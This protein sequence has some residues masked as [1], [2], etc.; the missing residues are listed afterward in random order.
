MA[1]DT[2]YASRASV[3]V[4]PLQIVKAKRSSSS[5]SRRA[6]TH[7][8]TPSLNTRPQSSQHHITPPPTPTLQ[9]P[10]AQ[11][12]VTQLQTQD[13]QGLLEQRPSDL[14]V[15]HFLRAFFPFHPTLNPSSNTVTLPLNIGDII[16]VHSV[17]TNGWADG[18]MLSSGSRGWLPTNY[19]EGYD[20][21]QIRPL[22]RA[23]LS[24]FDQCK[25]SGSH[26]GGNQG[27]VTG[28][29]AGVRYLLVGFLLF[30][31]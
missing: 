5:A 12:G 2:D 21:E 25:G 4:A 15:H 22:L 29:V 3:C 9:S 19:C 13:N 8:R 11:P 23:C 10:Q 30:R 17:H 16:L 27:V 14:L 20:L 18:T 28:V 24:L 6:H 7:S 31:F 1:D 26:Q